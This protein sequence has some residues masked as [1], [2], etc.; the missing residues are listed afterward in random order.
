MEYTYHVVYSYSTFTLVIV[1]MV[2]PPGFRISDTCV[3]GAAATINKGLHKKVTSESDF[4]CG[5]VFMLDRCEHHTLLTNSV[6][7]VF[8]MRIVQ[9][10]PNN[11]YE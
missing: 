7:A 11:L 2:P 10:S 9:P 6:M 8:G 1:R 5:M 3:P 4:P